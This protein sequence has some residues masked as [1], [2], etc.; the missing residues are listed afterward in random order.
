M[1]SDFI[2]KEFLIWLWHKSEILEG[3]Y[4]FEDEII[5]IWIDDYILLENQSGDSRESR[6]AKGD[7]SISPEAAMAL[8]DGKKVKE[9]KVR[10]EFTEELVAT[11]HIK[12]ATLQ[13]GGLRFPVILK[14]H[15]DE[16]FIERLHWL[17]RVEQLMTQLFKDFSHERLEADAW[18]SRRQ[19]INTWME[20]KWKGCSA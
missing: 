12:G 14:E 13:I 4:R 10:V 16:V 1:A 5:H 7:P 20:E 15:A 9:C 8:W 6:L 17:N 11:F 18:K 2:G 3:R 19:S